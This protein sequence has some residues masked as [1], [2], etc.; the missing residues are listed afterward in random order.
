MN[1]SAH[2]HIVWHENDQARTVAFNVGARYATLAVELM[3]G[4]VMLPFNTRHLG[5]SDYGLWM[6]AASIVAYFPV[7]DLGYGGALERFVAHYR[8]RRDAGAI[9]EIAST[10]IVMFAAMGLVALAIIAAIAWNLGTLFDLDPVQARTGGAVMLL[11][12]VQFA[13]G[14]PFGVFGAVVNGFQR[15]YLNSVVSIGVSV[16]VLIVNVA[17]VLS[18]GTLVQLVGAMTLTRMLGFFAYRVNAYR[19]YPLLRIRRSLCRL[20]RLREMAQFSVYMLVQDVSTRVNYASD[21]IVIAAALS[22]GA[23]AVWT[24]AQRLADVVL[25]LTNQLNYVLFPVVV[26]C[27]TAQRNDRLRD[28]LVHGTRFSLATSLP[29]AGSLMLLAEPVVAGWTS[30]EFRAAAPVLQILTLVVLVRV[31]SAT[32]STVLQGGGH[33]RL[34]SASNL[35]AA[36]TNVVLSVV[37]IRTHGLPGVAFA[38]LLPL[39]IRASGVLIPVACRRVGL[40]V[41]SF[42]ATAI[43]PALWP[44]A[45]ALGGLLLVRDSASLSLGHAVL[46]GAAIGL[47]YWAIFLGVAITRSDRHRYLGKMRSIAGWPA[48]KAA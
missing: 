2:P 36:V 43:W 31:G 39:A 32:A 11:V 17:V 29:V 34:L 13:V 9:N 24:V 42:C 28:L 30:T 4:L 6:L 40:S 21:P 16:A 26:D 18:G 10:L 35:V 23:V 12:A 15:T 48:L 19:V 20:S 44:A 25:Q 37:L 27:D 33:L 1:G 41:R 8:A 47:A 3:L 7:I 45:F 38:T 14:F 22:T 5:A 46:H